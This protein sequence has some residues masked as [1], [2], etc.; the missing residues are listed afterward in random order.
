MHLNCDNSLLVLQLFQVPHFVY[1]NMLQQTNRS[2]YGAQ[3]H[4][5]SVNIEIEA[6]KCETLN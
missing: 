6:R 4:F 2:V 3:E 1:A 5:S